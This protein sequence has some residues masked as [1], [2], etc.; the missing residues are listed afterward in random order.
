M[1][2]K[3]RCPKGQGSR[4]PVET[5]SLRGID[6][7]LLA[8]R[9]PQS[10]SHSLSTRAFFVVLVAV[11]ATTFSW[12]AQTTIQQLT[13]SPSTLHFGTV[14]LGQ[15]ETQ[16]ITLT[17]T[18]AS[19]VT[20][21]AMNFVR[22]GQFGFPELSLPLALAAG[23]SIDLSV[24]F[25]PTAPGW[26]GGNTT[27]QS[28]AANPTLQLQFDG[29]GVKS[30]VVV[31]SPASVSF[32][33]V[34]VGSSS[35]KT[36]T[37]TNARTWKVSVSG[38]QTIGSE[39]STSAP[40]MPLTLAGGQSA[41]FTVTFT[42]QSSGSVGGSLLFSDPRLN[43]PF[44]G[45]GT[46]AVASSQLT[47]SPAVVNFGSVPVGSTQTETISMSA[48]GA[49]VTVSADSSSNSQFALQG[50]SFPLTIAAGQSLSFSVAFK[51]TSSGAESGSLA[52]A[53]NATS[54]S[55]A[56]SLTGTGT[57]IATSQLTVS[58][59][60]VSFGSV[61]VGTTQTESIT[62]S[63]SGAAVTVSSDSSSNS[64]F[65]L[66]AAFPMTIAAG[67]SMTFNVAF[68]PTSSGAES[69]TLAFA[70]NANSSSGPAS[71]SGT[72]TATTYSVNLSWNASSDVAGYN[73]YRSTTATGTY[74][75]I[76]PS[77]DANTAYTDSTV[78]AGQTYY[79]EATS[80]NSSGQESARSTPPVVAAVP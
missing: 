50:A 16:L 60:A 72:G 24:T 30:D 32:G 49:P 22:E 74:A 54:S 36:I 43:V 52:F 42:P 78:V 79:Y 8:M 20:L 48:S 40:S 12:G 73:V 6:F 9:L 47:V 71:L 46:A 31:A 44:T 63:A 28:N 66:E 53:S 27:F 33:Q 1:Q 21:T 11:Y 65:I 23:Q 25:T 26:A 69:G 34:A 39:F 13:C 7:T 10:I 80:V 55:A 2:R 29:S 64:Q 58:P 67:S 17:N 70:S 38:F 45:T 19:S 61:P 51:P 76:N 62:M 59:A 75:K 37:L 4:C 5:F 56:E 35:T 68:T 3:G 57:A 77:V 41:T 15:T 18:G 14:P